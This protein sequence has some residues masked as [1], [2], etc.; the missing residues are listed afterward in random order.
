MPEKHPDSV[1]H[2][3]AWHE[4]FNRTHDTLLATLDNKSKFHNEDKDK[5]ERHLRTRSLEELKETHGRVTH[6][7]SEHD[8]KMATSG[9]MVDGE[10]KDTD[11]FTHKGFSFKRAP[12]GNDGYQVHD[13][14]GNYVGSWGKIHLPW[15]KEQIDK[16]TLGSGVKK[17]HVAGHMRQTKGGK[18][19]AVRE[20][21]DS[22]PVTATKEQAAGMR[23]HK[24]AADRASDKADDSG[25][26]ADHA[27]AAKEHKRA[28]EA[29]LE[30][31]PV[32]RYHKEMAEYHEA[33]AAKAGEHGD[34]GSKKFD[35]SE[36]DKE[37]GIGYGKR[38]ATEEEAK[39]RHSR[40]EY[41]KTDKKVPFDEYHKKLW[42][43]QP[44]SKFDKK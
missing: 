20:H 38:M 17:S 26:A 40:I 35:P 16:G 9:N 34:H 37:R 3:E 30:R 27:E 13:K 5:L 25:S 18:V 1:T 33:A 21:E 28:H 32:K 15:V 31:H 24:E 42:S 39:E 22:R 6:T 10:G 44:K 4:Q 41:D 11:K 19:V 23:V 36:F 7:P 12:H 29:A 14:E 8:L 43:N 2:K